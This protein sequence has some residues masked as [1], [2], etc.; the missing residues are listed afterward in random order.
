ML[1]AFIALM[2]LRVA[3]GYHFFVEGST[4]LQDKN[5]TAEYFLKGAKGPAAPMFHQMVD[6][7]KGN[8]R[9]CIDETKTVDGE[10]KYV[11]N[12]ALTEG[13]WKDYLDKKSAEVSND[14]SVDV[15][16]L[17]LKRADYEN[18]IKALRQQ[19]QQ[20]DE[21]LKQHLSELGSWLDDNKTA[22]VAHYATEDRLSGFERDGNNRTQ[23]ALHVDSVRSQVDSV[24]YDRDKLLAGWNAEVGTI[25]DSFENSV[26]NLAVGPQLE[27]EPL[28]L[29][30][31]FDQP[32][33]KLKVINKVIPWFDTIVGVLLILGLFTRLASAAG[34]LF[35]LSVIISQPPWIPGTKTTFYESI[36]MFAMF[37]IF[38]TC[39]GR[40]GGLDF[41]FSQP[42][43]SD[44]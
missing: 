3:V 41:F 5:W 17:E 14:Q 6:D 44:Q 29:H 32:N 1:L 33:S 12:M 9:L 13:I 34:G 35:L 19:A 16:N 20:A 31:P 40:Y 37:A 10:T 42:S 39:A 15:V 30:R 2:M 8:V 23:V 36:E 4:K 18:S 38:A 28:A 21:I 26:N 43:K 7:E 27:K 24:R 22:L 25:W 11:I